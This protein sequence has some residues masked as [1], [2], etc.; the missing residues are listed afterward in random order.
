MAGVKKYKPTIKDI[1]VAYEKKGANISATCKSLGIDRKTF[2]NRRKANPKLDEALSEIEEGLID[3]T[4]SKLIQAI[5][6][7]NLTA[8]I[9]YLKTK[10]KER[11]YI[12]RQE[13]QVTVNPFEELMKLLPEIPDK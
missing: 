9:F 4:E 7:D 2:Y 10:G 12:E 13:Q 1:V 11:G 3:F 6:D 5:N 8:I